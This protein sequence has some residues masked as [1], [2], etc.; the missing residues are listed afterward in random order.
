MLRKSRHG[1]PET[2]SETPGEQASATRRRQTGGL[3][4]LL[5][6]KYFIIG[7]HLINDTKL[8]FSITTAKSATVALKHTLDLTVLRYKQVS[9]TYPACEDTAENQL[10]WFVDAYYPGGITLG[11]FV[12]HCYFFVKLVQTDLSAVCRELGA[13]GNGADSLTERA[14]VCYRSLSDQQHPTH[15]GHS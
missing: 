14:R 2:V 10:L 13:D 3:S 4:Q 12:L 11:R 5:P 6:F 8:W 7:D 9:G 1:R 15:A